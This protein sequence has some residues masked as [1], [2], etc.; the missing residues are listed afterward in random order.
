[1]LPV[2]LSKSTAGKKK[3]IKNNKPTKTPPEQ[4][5]ALTFYWL[6]N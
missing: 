4:N 1:M 2:D 5:T 6:E 3:E